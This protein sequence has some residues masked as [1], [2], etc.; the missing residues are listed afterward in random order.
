MLKRLKAKI[1]NPSN[2]SFLRALRDLR[3]RHFG[4]NH[5]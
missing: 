3:V 4:L 1:W 2:L 5:E